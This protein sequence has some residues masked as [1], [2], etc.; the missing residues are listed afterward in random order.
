MSTNTKQ[1]KFFKF[2]QLKEKASQNFTAQDVVIATGWTFSTFKS[3]LSKGQLS[4]FVSKT[5]SNEFEAS[6]TLNLSF[7]EFSKKL[8][9][10]KNRRALGHNCKSL[11]AKAL[12]NKCRDN[13]MLALELY[14]RPSL[15]NKMDGFV[16]LFCCAWEQLL[17][18]KIIESDGEQSIYT[19]AKRNGIKQTISLRDCLKLVFDSNNKIKTNIETIADFRDQ[20]VHLLMPE[21]QGI[22]SRI[23][24]SG[25]LNFSS[26][27]EEFT[28]IPFINSSHT[29]MI[30]LV[31]DFKTPPVSMLKSTYGQTADEIVNT[32]ESLTRTVEG[33]DDIE[34]AI[35]LN[36]K[37]VFAKDDAEGGQIV[38][39]KAEDGMTGLKKALVIEKPV[40]VD[41]SHPYLQND[42][43]KEIN[44]RLHSKFEIHK[45]KCCLVFKKE[46]NL[47]IGSNCFQALLY[48]LGWKKTNSKYHHHIKK[49]A[50]HKYSDAALDEMIKKLTTIDGYLIMAK[51]SYSARLN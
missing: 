4:D 19:K 45:L 8:S 12:L 31:G 29:G 25:V 43:I 30:S 1:T 24:Q 13:M 27:F 38:L 20:A 26:K 14:N 39:T 50:V 32:A 6:N 48:K 34:F 15:E 17:K 47:A 18:A 3:Y 11:L 35:P 16:M 33:Y 10:S 36:V 42:A 22:I 37:L 49:P 41:K 7:I 51:K 21:I 28:E 2:L 44:K 9:Q 40:D 46:G 23:F 5:T